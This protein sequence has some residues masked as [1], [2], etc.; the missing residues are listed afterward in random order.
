MLKG[1]IS[2]SKVMY[3]MFRE[4]HRAGSGPEEEGGLPAGQEGA[5]G[6]PRE[7]G[8]PWPCTLAMPPTIANLAC[9]YK[10]PGEERG[11]SSQLPR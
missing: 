2:S 3:L 6:T 1:K 10:P 5:P 7:V 9:R 8:A 11:V 4:H